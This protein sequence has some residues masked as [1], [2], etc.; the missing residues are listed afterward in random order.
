MQIHS[1]YATVLFW[2]FFMPAFAQTAPPSHVDPAASFAP[3]VSLEPGHAK[4]IPVRPLDQLSQDEMAQF[5][6]LWTHLGAGDVPPYPKAGTGELLDLVAQRAKELRAREVLIVIADIDEAGRVTH[7]QPRRY[8][9][10]Q[11]LKAVTWLLV[12]TPFLPARCNGQPCK[13]TFPLIARVPK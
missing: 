10:D 7:V 2:I 5:R 3:L 13:S 6:Q 11:L 9:D 8:S 12:D 4:F 1:F